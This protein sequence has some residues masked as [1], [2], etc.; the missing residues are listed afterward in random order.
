MSARLK[1]SSRPIDNP[2]VLAKKKTINIIGLNSGTSADGLDIALIK[3]ESNRKPEFVKRKT[4]EFPAELK[5]AIIAAGEP[6]NVN[7]VDWL[8]LD[9]D[10]G[11]IMGEYAKSFIQS[12]RKGRLKADLIGSHGQ[13][14]RHLPKDFEHPLTLQVGD[15][16]LIAAISGLPVIGDFRRSDLAAG[17][18]GAPLSP[19]LHQLL[20]SNRRHWRAIVNIGG[21]SNA[22]ILPPAS[23]NSKLVA[24]DCGPG[25]MLVDLAM[26][27]LYN[28][29][30][31]MDGATAL[32]GHPPMAVVSRILQNRYFELAPPK[33]T[34]REMFGQQ[35]LDEVLSRM[36]S[37]FSEDIIATVSE[38]T[39]AGIADF[40]KR[41]GKKT[42]EIYLCGGG[43][44][45]NY[46]MQRLGQA[47]PGKLISTTEK[48]GYDP[49]HLE[50]LLWAYLALKFIKQEPIEARHFTGAEKPY[51][52]G[53]LCLP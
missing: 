23:S 52:P 13:T 44:K 11:R 25:N 24:G 30:Y 53:K 9:S 1:T 48:L 17:G 32:K 36:A 20:F 37:V 47:F 18:Q 12:L 38:V 31:D 49:D 5:R 46:F 19:V 3:F 40:I 7:G 22:T 41:F 10:L 2:F 39:V 34:G 14:I 29:P 21:I 35:F 8:R 42:E 33:S 4:F 26:Q 28:Q 51:I 43:A 16:S 45:N 27:K 50:S 15:P 6:E